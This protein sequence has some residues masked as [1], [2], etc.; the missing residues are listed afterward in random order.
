MEEWK[1]IEGYEGLYQ[2]SNLG[3]V[4]SL[5]H[6]A[7]NG[8]T[9]ILYRGKVL[10]QNLGTNGYYSVQLCKNNIPKRREIHRLV[11][12]TF[13]KRT[14][15]KDIVNHKDE[16]KTNNHVDNLEWCTPTYNT[17]YGDAISKRSERMK[18]RPNKKKWVKV[19]CNETGVYYESVKHAAEATGVHRSAISMVLNGKR[20][21]AGGYTWAVL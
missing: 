21:K 6:Y 15:G 18:G 8:R 4:R 9:M 13:L 12:E 19:R 7:S 10:S 14:S 16:V 11:A 20:V 5:D 1:D 3:R 2:V 17:N